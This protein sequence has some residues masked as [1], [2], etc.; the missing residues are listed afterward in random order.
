MATR[1]DVRGVFVGTTPF[2]SDDIWLRDN[3]VVVVPKGPIL[4]VDDFVNLVFTRG[5]FSCIPFQS[6]VAVR[7]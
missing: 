5:I 2:P 7:F 1:L 3:D 4:R 6:T